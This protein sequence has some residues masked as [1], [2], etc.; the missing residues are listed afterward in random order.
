MV[1]PIKPEGGMSTTW[2]GHTSSQKER[3]RINVKW[4]CYDPLKRVCEEHVPTI[5]RPQPMWSIER[6]NWFGWACNSLQSSST[7]VWRRSICKRP[8]DLWKAP[9]QRPDILSMIEEIK[10]MFQKSSCEQIFLSLTGEVKGDNTD[11]LV[12]D[13]PIYQPDW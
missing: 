12:K 7:S 3:K 13:F 6:G 1:N 10:T 8:K 9:F 11:S 5:N 4:V 2:R